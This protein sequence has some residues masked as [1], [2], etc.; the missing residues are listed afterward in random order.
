MSVLRTMILA[1]SENPWLRRQATRRRFIRRAVSRFMPGESFEEALTAARSLAGQGIS[2]ILT[3]LGENVNDR[4]EAAAEVD[5]Y[6][7][8]L[9]H[10]AGSGLD[11]EISIKLT[12]L[13]LDLGPEVADENLDRL[14]TLAAPSQTRLWIDMEG[15]AYT[16][17]TIECYR[18]I[19]KRHR[20]VGLAMQAYLRRTASDLASLLPD[21]PIVRL[22]KG[23]YREPASIAFAQMSEVNE[24]FFTLSASLLSEEARRAGAWLAVG[25]HDPRLI[26]RIAAHAA[27][28]GVPREAY[29]YAMLYGIRRDEQARLVGQR[30][31]VRVLISYGSQW[32]PWYMRRLAERPAN[33]WF[34]ARSAFSS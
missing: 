17:R 3:N 29:E 31:R 10:L 5:H 25:T 15:S 9:R 20:N 1:G 32:F 26:E 7:E 21:G 11:A 13:G 4:A 33:L 19:R 14:A 24:S 22:V 8:V 34:V 18:R 27:S 16:E 28:A 6:G 2:V 12:H 23:A 30:H